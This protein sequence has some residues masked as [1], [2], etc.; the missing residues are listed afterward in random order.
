MVDEALSRR[1]LEGGS[2]ALTEAEIAA[3]YDKLGEECGI[4]TDHADTDRYWA[5]ELKLLYDDMPAVYQAQ[6]D[7]M[8]SD[9][10]RKI[11]EMLSESART[12]VK[13]YEDHS[14]I[15][16]HTETDSTGETIF[17]M[18][19]APKPT[20]I[21]ARIARMQESTFT[22]RFHDFSRVVRWAVR[23]PVT[24]SISV[25]IGQQPESAPNSVTRYPINLYLLD[26]Y[27]AMTAV[28]HLPS[29]ADQQEA[30]GVITSIPKNLSL[31]I[32]DE[33]RG[34]LSAADQKGAHIV[35]TISPE[36]NVN[37]SAMFDDSGRATDT[38]VRILESLDAAR[39]RKE[40]RSFI[41]FE[42]NLS[43]VKSMYTIAQEQYS[44]DPEVLKGTISISRAALCNHLGI[45]YSNRQRI[46]GDDTST[47]ITSPATVIADAE[48]FYDDIDKQIMNHFKSC[49]NVVA[50]LADGS[51]YFLLNLQGYDAK[52]DSYKITLPYPAAVAAA[53]D[54]K[55]IEKAQGR[56]KHNPNFG[57][58]ALI[59]GDIYKCKNE[60]AK[61]ILEYLLAKMIERGES[62]QTGAKG[63][64]RVEYEVSCATIIDNIPD[65]QIKLDSTIRKGDKNVVL[66]R[67]FVGVIDTGTNGIE[68]KNIFSEYT[69]AYTYF[70]DL[71]ITW[72]I[73]T[74]QTLR[75]T[76]IRISWKPKK[77][78]ADPVI[79]VQ[80]EKPKR[81]K[82]ATE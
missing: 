49:R 19:D 53:V 31:P 26:C 48:Q 58:N 59:H 64:K 72:A 76:K 23:R 71:K 46:K 62:N 47:A 41:P 5:N 27:E 14:Q 13:M 50:Y 43:F 30:E 18:K 73:P 68:K 42:G 7:K 82:K 11:F 22:S 34:A 55:R 1:Y 45:R 67:A 20:S 4:D 80:A 16:D 63:S 61:A 15:V 33:Y 75:E 36:V 81:R 39:S 17:I 35:G 66:K 37:L 51:W 70:D 44:N 21:E 57:H 32:F 74:I 77:E 60:P 40:K 52:T 24:V 65:I 9:Q 79:V 25:K 54:K 78:A 3:Y 2:A 38:G 28:Y 29:E 69:D 56:Q 8:G 12:A 6:V 10:I